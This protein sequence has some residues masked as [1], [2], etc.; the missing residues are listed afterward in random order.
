MI[1]ELCRAAPLFVGRSDLGDD[2]CVFQEDQMRAI[3]EMLGTPPAAPR[4]APPLP[5]WH[6][7]C[8][9][10][11]RANALAEGSVDGIDADAASLLLRLLN[12]DPSARPSA[13]DALDDAWFLRSP[14]PSSE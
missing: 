10:P 6:V 4:D 5:R 13:R 8:R 1:G 9:W 7:V 11:R 14:L 3:V 12:Y 2:P